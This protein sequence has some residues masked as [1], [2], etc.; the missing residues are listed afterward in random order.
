[1]RKTFQL[2]LLLLLAGVAVGW[3]G[4]VIDR[5]AATVNGAIILDSEVDDAVRFGALVEGRPLAG[6][7]DEERK[8][9]LQR[10]ID[11]ELLHQQ[12]GTG[13]FR[14]RQN[15]IPDRIA[16]IR[17]Q[18]PEAA[19]EPGW[20]AVLA[21]YGMSQADL[22]EQISL[23]LQLLRF[24]DV[25]LRPAVHIDRQSIEAY[26]RDRYLPELRKA[27][28][29]HDVPLPQ[30][31][32]RIEEVLAQQQVDEQ[33]NNWL[34]NLR[35]QSVIRTEQPVFGPAGEQGQ[36]RPERDGKAGDRNGRLHADWDAK[37]IN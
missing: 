33:L 26:Y 14:G 19:T 31:S 37:T 2:A 21:R 5:I 16:Q 36:H 18:Y 22:E 25:R 8:A 15:E 11:R 23:Q 3:C 27:G 13:R 29:T 6:I 1:M 20:Q 4:E 10:L 28:A 9:A 34:R 30:V 12:M 32:A 24:I 35:Q 17:K 7:T